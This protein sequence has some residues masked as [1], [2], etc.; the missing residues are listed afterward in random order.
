MSRYPRYSMPDTSTFDQDS[1][2]LIEIKKQ[3][4]IEADR[5]KD[6]NDAFLKKK[7]DMQDDKDN[8]MDKSRAEAR[9]GGPDGPTKEEDFE[10]L[11]R[12]FS[13][14]T[15]FTRDQDEEQYNKYEKIGQFKDRMREDHGPWLKTYW[16]WFVLHNPPKTPRWIIEDDTDGGRS[17]TSR[18]KKSIAKRS[19]KKI[20]KRSSRRKY[21]KSSRV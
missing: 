14:P 11:D 12:M 3:A 6:E 5:L 20:K 19:S 18:Q 7:R 15:S 21:Y 8:A 16:S 4:K 13:H 9:K 2:D 17:K 1:E 10:M